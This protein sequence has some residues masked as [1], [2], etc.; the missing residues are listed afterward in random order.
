MLV[1]SARCGRLLATELGCP[2]GAAARGPAAGPHRVESGPGTLHTSC[3]LMGR[4]SVSAPAVLGSWLMGSWGVELCGVVAAALSH[5]APLRNFSVR[6]IFS[7]QNPR[8]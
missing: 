1:T 4:W 8:E 6:W 7:V 5:P 2:M 3:T